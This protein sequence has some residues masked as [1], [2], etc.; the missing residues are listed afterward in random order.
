TQ[1]A[2]TPSV[3]VPVTPQRVLDTRF[4]IGLP[5]TFTG[6]QSRTLDVTGAV[7]VVL[8]GNIAG[9][10]TVVPAG[11]TAIVANVTAIRPTSTGYVSVRPGDATGTPTTSTLNIPT[12]GGLYPNSVTVELPTTGNRS[13]TVDLFYFADT[14]GGRTHLLFDVVGYYIPGGAGIPGPAGP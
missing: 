14:P 2:S 9:S 4:D 12:A 6:G 8:P 10:S 5:G 3:F 13:G 11:A 7:P 1:A